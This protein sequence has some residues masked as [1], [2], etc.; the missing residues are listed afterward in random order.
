PLPALPIS[1]WDV[2]ISCYTMAYVDAEIVGAVLRNVRSPRMVIMEP[3][4]RIAP[5][6]EPGTYTGPAMPCY[7]HDYMELARAAGWQALWRWP[8]Y[9]HHQCL[10]VVLTLERT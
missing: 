10:N 2:T 5:F 8:L 9:P 6:G 1:T 4:A 7:V 3:T